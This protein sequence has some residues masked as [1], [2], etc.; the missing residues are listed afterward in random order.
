M[1]PIGK[2]GIITLADEKSVLSRE[3]MVDVREE[4]VDLREETAD[5]RERYCATKEGPHEARPHAPR[6]SCAKRT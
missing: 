1:N 6:G 2:G 4:V 3:K 5:M